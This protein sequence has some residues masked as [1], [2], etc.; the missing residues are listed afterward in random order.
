MGAHYDGPPQSPGADDN[1][2]G[3]AVLLELAHRWQAE[4]IRRPVWLVA[5]DQEE[6][7]LLGSRAL[8]SQLREI[9]RA[10]V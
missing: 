1:A 3:L 7:G 10:H 2:T 4:P 9:G 8:A 5:F 6:E